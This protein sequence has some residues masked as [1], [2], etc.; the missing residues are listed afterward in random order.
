MIDVTMTLPTGNSILKHCIK[1]GELE[2][3]DLD[4]LLRCHAITQTRI[5]EQGAKTEEAKLAIAVQVRKESAA[6]TTQTAQTAQTAAVYM[7]EIASKRERAKAARYETERKT[8][9]AT[10]TASTT[11]D[12]KRMITLTHEEREQTYLTTVHPGDGET[13]STPNSTIVCH[14]TGK[15]Q[16]GSTFDCSR[17]KEKEFEAKLGTHSL[18]QGWEWALTKMSL[19]ERIELTIA[20]S[21]AYAERGVPGHIPPWSTLIFDV[22]LLQIDDRRMTDELC[23]ELNAQLLRTIKENK[24]AEWVDDMSME[25]GSGSGSGS[26]S[27][28]KKKGGNGGKSGKG[29]KK[30]KKKKKR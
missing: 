8:V 4:E 21:W 19:G 11:K 29:K 2:G 14:Y 24:L 17:E 5:N 25:S 6:Q 27:E 9:L 10:E 16:D 3:Y 1:S 22:Q 12:G 13:Y 30:K 26:N 23:I 20:P 28:K 18:I 15:L 7:Q